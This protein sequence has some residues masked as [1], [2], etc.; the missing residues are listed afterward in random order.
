MFGGLEMYS[1]V[2]LL[3]ATTSMDATS[4]HR[5][6]GRGYCPPPCCPPPPCCGSIGYAPFPGGPGPGPG[7]GPGV[8][9]GKTPAQKLTPA[10]E[11]QLAELMGQ[12]KKTTTMTPA[13]F[14]Q[15]EAW[16]RNISPDQRAKE[17]KEQMKG[18][19]TPPV[20]PAAPLSVDEEKMLKDLMAKFSTKDPKTGKAD[21]D[22][23]GLKQ[24][25]E[26]FRQLPPADRLKE[27]EKEIK[28]KKGEI[29]APAQLMVH[30]P[31]DAVLTI[32]GH[33]TKS[34]AG[35]RWFQSPALNSRGVHFYELQ[36]TVERAGMLIRVNRLVR[37]QPGQLTE[38]NI[39]IPSPQ[40][41]LARQR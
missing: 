2:L 3:A 15:Y 37:V 39:D 19:V 27:Y 23:K 12:L 16:F 34:S 40:Y 38:V 13:E 21:L 4:C 30:L 28:G 6:R 32:D 26:W 36:A 1:V 20:K 18:P 31:H 14:K 22:E 24:Y 41:A 11:K 7:P 5:N 17:Y 25:D 33:G 35:S 29:S 9:P 8:T 10:E